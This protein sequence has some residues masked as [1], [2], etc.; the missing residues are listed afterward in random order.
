M[1][2]VVL[3]GGKGERLRPF[4]E[5][6]PKPWEPA[7]PVEEN[8]AEYVDW[9][10]GQSGTKHYLEEAEEVMRQRGVLLRVER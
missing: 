1:Y 7:I 3:A 2:A 6:R 4:T 5:D 10:R 9:I 8:V